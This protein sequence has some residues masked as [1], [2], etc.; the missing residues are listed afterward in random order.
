MVSGLNGSWDV[1]EDL[2]GHERERKGDE[3][4]RAEAHAQW[5]AQRDEQ[6]VQQLM[7]GM[8][9]GFRKP[10]GPSFLQDEAT[11]TPFPQTIADQH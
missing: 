7:E 4:K 9:N 10:K 3:R 6:D 8:R 11:P 2:I 5:L 1:Q